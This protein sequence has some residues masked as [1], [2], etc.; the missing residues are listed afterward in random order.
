[1]FG[2]LM[3][4]KRGSQDYSQRRASIEEM[5]TKPASWFNSTFNSTFRGIQKTPAE[6][7]QTKK[8]EEMKRGVME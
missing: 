1:M 7:Q 2:N 4:H 5:E 8:A 6:Q 3:T